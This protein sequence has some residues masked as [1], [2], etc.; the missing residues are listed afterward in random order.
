M[1]LI[2]LFILFVLTLN[3]FAQKKSLLI[4]DI[5]STQTHDWI[6]CKFI[7]PSEY[8][9][10][11][12]NYKIKNNRR[13][14]YSYQIVPVSN[15]QR[16]RVI[17]MFMAGYIQSDSSAISILISFFGGKPIEYNNSIIGVV[18]DDIVIAYKKLEL[19]GMNYFFT[20]STKHNQKKENF[21][22]SKIIWFIDIANKWELFHEK[23]H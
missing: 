2:V 5:F 4:K 7:L 12:V 18:N 19:G 17:E 1:K 11:K 6:D 9:V 14:Y 3:S 23:P 22:V 15:I 16:S 20:I 8:K 10:K 13:V 21:D